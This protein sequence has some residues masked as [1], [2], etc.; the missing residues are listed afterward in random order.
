MFGAVS[1]MRPVD[2]LAQNFYTRLV[3]PAGSVKI[4]DMSLSSTVLNYY[5]DQ[6][7]V[8]LGASKTMN[9]C[10]N[11]VLKKNLSFNTLYY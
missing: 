9:L 5:G 1:S 2:Y 4:A 6:N 7:L 10:S 3:Q 11:L 8:L